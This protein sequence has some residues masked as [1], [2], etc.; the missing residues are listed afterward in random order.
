MKNSRK[1][2]EEGKASELGQRGII[3][4]VDAEGTTVVQLLQMK[5]TYISRKDATGGNYSQ[6]VAIPGKGGTWQLSTDLL[7]VLLFGI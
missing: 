2:R 6:S 1:E 3:P 5:E 4:S 7:I